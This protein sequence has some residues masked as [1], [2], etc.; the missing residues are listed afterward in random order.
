MNV[1]EYEYHSLQAGRLAQHLKTLES[2]IV[3][4]DYNPTSFGA[5]GKPILHCLQHINSVAH[6]QVSF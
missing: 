3:W 6:A 5:H 1:Q 2:V 4:V